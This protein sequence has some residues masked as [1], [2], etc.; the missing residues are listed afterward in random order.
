MPRLTQYLRFDDTCPFAE[1]FAAFRDPTA[2]ARIDSAVRKLARGL[3][4][5]VKPVGEGVHEARIDYGPGY[6]V[7]FAND[8]GDLVVLLVCGDKTTQANDIDRARGF[9]ADYTTRK[10]GGSQGP[11]TLPPSRPRRQ[12]RRP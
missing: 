6:R 3:K 2:K 12:K 10:P 1:A 5:D 7:Y 9:W 8:G 11:E 4:P